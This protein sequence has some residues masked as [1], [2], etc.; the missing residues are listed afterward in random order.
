MSFL[1]KALP[2]AAAPMTGGLSLALLG[3]KGSLKDKIFGEKDMGTPDR[4]IDLD[5][6]LKNVVEQARP[7]QQQGLAGLQGFMNQWQGQD[8]RKIGNLVTQ[9][10]L[11][12]L[13]DQ[14]NANIRQA[15]RALAQRG[16]AGNTSL[17]LKAITDAQREQNKGIMAANAQRPLEELGALGTIQQGYGQGL[18]GVNAVLGASGPQSE[19]QLGRQGTGQRSGGLF[20]LA[21][22]IGGAALGGA[23]GGPAGIGPGAQ[24]GRGLGGV[25]SNY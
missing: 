13:R 12:T 3:G 6:S 8:Y 22:T 7:I 14:A 11:N 23:M 25:I 4:V 16:I 19:I 1:D 5:P 24:I 15:N 18:S 9:N 17:G 20:G 2:V 21:T 10:K